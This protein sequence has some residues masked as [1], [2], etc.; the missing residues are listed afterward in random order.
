[1]KNVIFLIVLSISFCACSKLSTQ[2]E[3]VNSKANFEFKDS[4]QPKGGDIR[5]IIS[6]PNYKRQ[7]LY[8]VYFINYDIN[9][10]NSTGQNIEKTDIKAKLLIYYDYKTETIDF[11]SGTFITQ[12]AYMWGKNSTQK[13]EQSNMIKNKRLFEHE[14]NKIELV[15]NVSVQNSV[16]FYKTE[17]FVLKD[18]LIESWQT[19]N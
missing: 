6:D 10:K 2:V 5:K 14:P 1:M 12:N 15:L 7:T 17:R 4:Y 16:G 13:F 9:L 3:L 11:G 18:G 8:D 19:L